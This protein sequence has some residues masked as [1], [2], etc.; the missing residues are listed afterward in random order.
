MK[1]RF[2]GRA[3]VGCLFAALALLAAALWSAWTGDGGADA[4]ALSAGAALIAAVLAVVLFREASYL[5]DVEQSIVLLDRLAAQDSANAGRLRA[6][7]ALR[8]AGVPGL[9]GVQPADAEPPSEPHVEPAD[10]EPEPSR[11]KALRRRLSV[12]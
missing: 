6:E 10:T 3:A 1:S 8:L 2:A 11:W 5:H 9:P 4:L 7:V 12:K